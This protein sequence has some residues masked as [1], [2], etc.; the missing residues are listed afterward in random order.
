V[1]YYATKV[2]LSP[3]TVPGLKA[4]LNEL[5]NDALVIAK[6]AN[7][8]V[9]NAVTIADNNYFLEDQKFAPGDGQLHYYLYNYL[10]NPIAGGVDKHNMIDEHG[11][12]IGLVM[13]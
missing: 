1:F 3:S 5:M 2:A 12:S 7:F 6:K 13:L 11:S 4:R 9:F 8:D 10:A